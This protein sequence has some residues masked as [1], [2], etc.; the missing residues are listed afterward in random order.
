MYCF[1]RLPYFVLESDSPA[2][3]VLGPATAADRAADRRL[4][5]FLLSKLCF[6]DMVARVG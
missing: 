1:L 4:P 6:S 5:G 3:D 2:A